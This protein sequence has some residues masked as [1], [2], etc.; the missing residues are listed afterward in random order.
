MMEVEHDWVMPLNKAG[1]SRILDTAA[2]T[3]ESAGYPAS[4]L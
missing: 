3:V 2:V 4:T 1:H